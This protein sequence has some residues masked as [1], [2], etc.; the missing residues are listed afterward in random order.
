MFDCLADQIRND[1]HVQ[2]S[3]AERYTRWFAVAVVSVVV[4]G[5]LF[6]SIHWLQ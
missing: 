2:V 4:F 1:E 3:N 6:L 5:G